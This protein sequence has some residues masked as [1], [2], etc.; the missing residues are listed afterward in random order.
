MVNGNTTKDMVLVSFDF[1]TKANFKVSLKMMSQLKRIIK[2]SQNSL[3]QKEMYLKHLALAIFMKGSYLDL[4]RNNI[5]MEIIMR[6]NLRTGKSQ[7]MGN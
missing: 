7:D 3:I 4:E 6:E 5:Q 1:Q 2:E